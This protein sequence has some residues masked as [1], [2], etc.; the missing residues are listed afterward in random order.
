MS[1]G[2]ERLEATDVAARDFLP[3][4]FWFYF[5][6]FGAGTPSQSS[7]YP[8]LK[9]L[10]EAKLHN[11]PL[12]TLE[13][14]LARGKPFVATLPQAALANPNGPLA[15]V[16]HV[17]LAWTY[18]FMDTTGQSHPSRFTG[19][20]REIAEGRRAGLAINAL[21][22]FA[23]ETH[24]DLATRVHEHEHAQV[25]NR[26]PSP[27]REPWPALWM[28]CQDLSGYVLLGDP[29]ARLPVSR[30]A[31]PSFQ[32]ADT[33]AGE[34]KPRAKA[35]RSARMEQAVLAM[36]AG[37]RTPENLA[38]EHGATKGEILEWLRIYMDAGRKALRKRSR[39]E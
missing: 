39:G 27:D 33:R 22:R 30:R 4:G 32:P 29:A 37:D 5:A 21:W 31:V 19:V 24:V 18:A 15:V 1:L 6:C 20:L 17:D 36:L 13:A 38:L 10:R 8:W 2:A 35:P 28:A 7:Y 9:H 23:V 3:G 26:T 12:E 16:G 11:E 34:Y 25:T 14:A